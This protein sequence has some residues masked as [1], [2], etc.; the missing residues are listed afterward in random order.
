MRGE[1]GAPLRHGLW[2]GLHRGGEAGD[3]GAMEALLEK[4]FSQ[5]GLV[6]PVDGFQGV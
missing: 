5:G 3:A 6:G 2:E 4:K 1:V